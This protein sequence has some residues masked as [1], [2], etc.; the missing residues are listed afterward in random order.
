ML[1]RKKTFILVLIQIPHA[2]LN[3]IYKIMTTLSSFKFTKM[4]AS[5]CIIIFLKNA[6]TTQLKQQNNLI[7]Q[8]SHPLFLTK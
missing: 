7:I 3:K 2:Q 8:H 4:T 1:L 5:R 6:L